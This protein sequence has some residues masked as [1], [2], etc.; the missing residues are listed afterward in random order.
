VAGPSRAFRPVTCVVAD[1]HPPLLQVVS[2]VLEEHGVDVLVRASDG[3]E[4]L[5]AIAALRPSV[6]ILDVVM[7]PLGGIEVARRIARAI[8]ATRAILYTGYAEHSVMVDA[9]DAGAYGFVSKGA[10]TAELVRA[11]EIVANGERYLDPR[12]TATVPAAPFDAR[13]PTLSAREREILRLLSEGNSNADVGEA[14][15]ISPDTVRTY[16]SRAMKKL[17][18]ET[19]TQAVAKAIRL[20]LID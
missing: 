2:A 1:D 15:H 14:L 20:S 18:A 10:P 16:L 4:A 9:F 12:L 17:E 8:P 19:R 3:E 7:Q 5:A 6:A 13:V 11:V